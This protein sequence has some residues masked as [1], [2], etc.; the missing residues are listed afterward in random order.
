MINERFWGRGGEEARPP[1]GHAQT[2]TFNER[3]VS[4]R[5]FCIFS[6][7]ADAPDVFLKSANSGGW[8]G[9]GLW[10]TMVASAASVR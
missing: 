8:G 6:G 4:C 3:S 5:C 1:R 7:V 2:H 10:G 9:G